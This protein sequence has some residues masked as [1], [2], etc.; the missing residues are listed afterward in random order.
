MLQVEKRNLG[1]TYVV[2]QNKLHQI[3]S[4]SVGHKKNNNN[5]KY[6]FIVIVGVIITVISLL[7]KK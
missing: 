4:I 1:Y 2:T 6:N 3:V 7:Y 5:N